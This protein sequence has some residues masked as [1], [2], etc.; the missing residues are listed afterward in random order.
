MFNSRISAEEYIDRMSTNIDV[1]SLNANGFE[2]KL[3][4]RDSY[5]EVGIQAFLI[6]VGE[7][8]GPVEIDTDKYSVF[9]LLEIMPAKYSPIQKVYNDIEV[10]IK[11][12]SVN[13]IISNLI[14]AN[15]PQIKVQIDRD[16]IETLNQIPGAVLVKK[17]HFPNRFVVP[18]TRIFPHLSRWFE[19]LLE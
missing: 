13:Q 16:I 14:I 5:G 1:E 9:I 7:I 15:T 3:V 6:K 18:Q 17:S 10:I 12:T 8:A 4:N 19:G 11:T 2:Q